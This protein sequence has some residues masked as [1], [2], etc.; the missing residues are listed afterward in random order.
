MSRIGKKAVPIPPKVKVEVKDGA[1]V[2][3]SPDGKKRLERKLTHVT[4][5]VGKDSVTVSAVDGSRAA[6]SCHGLY[7]TLIAN[8]IDGV[9]KGWSK[10]LE[11]EGAGYKA[12][13][14]GKVLVCTVGY[15]APKEFPI[16]AGI[17]VELPKPT[18]VVLKGIDK[19]LVGQTAAALRA[20]HKPDPYR[21]KGI[22]YSGEKAIRKVVKGK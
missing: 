17:D 9:T 2:V 4:V 14:K 18:T 1:V 19:E 5:A 10:T 22:R 12:E 6:R 15:S 21:G 7:R 3:V 20:L 16:P 13:L 8:M 11:I